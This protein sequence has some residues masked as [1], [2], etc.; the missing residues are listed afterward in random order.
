MIDIDYGPGV[1]LSIIIVVFIMPALYGIFFVDRY[2][3]QHKAEAE[4]DKSGGADAF[5]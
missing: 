4:S 3:R 5:K 2:W 1:L